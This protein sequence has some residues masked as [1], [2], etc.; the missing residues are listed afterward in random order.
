MA[1]QP[2]AE[3]GSFQMLHWSLE[4]EVAAEVRTAV[5]IEWVLDVDHVERKLLRMSKDVQRQ[6]PV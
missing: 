6:S 1:V 4:V 5:E 3:G 2:T